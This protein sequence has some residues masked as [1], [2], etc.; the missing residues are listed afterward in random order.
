MTA[1][2]QLSAKA[3]ARCR[4]DAM[5]RRARRI[6]R[7]VAAGAAILFSVAF[8]VI[9]VQLSSGHDPALAAASARVKANA[10]SAGRSSSAVGSE[11]S[12]SATSSGESSSEAA[13]SS[14]SE[15]SSETG[16]TDSEESAAS[17]S[18]VTTSQS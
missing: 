7:S 5:R 2:Q 4:R 17:P 8:L 1:E 15:T 14:G 10:T 13:E 11:E 3:L 12:S 18:P 9:Y 6:R 16:S